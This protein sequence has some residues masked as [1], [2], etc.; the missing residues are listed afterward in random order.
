[1]DEALALRHRIP[2]RK[3]EWGWVPRA[4]RVALPEVARRNGYEIPKSIPTVDATVEMCAAAIRDL[5]SLA[6][7]IVPTHDQSLAFYGWFETLTELE[8]RGRLVRAALADDI[9]KT[10]RLIPWSLHLLQNEFQKQK[11][12]YA[13]RYGDDGGWSQ[14]QMIIE[15]TFFLHMW[16]LLGE[17]AAEPVEVVRALT[18]LA[19]THPLLTLADIQALAAAT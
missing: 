12:P 6:R 14:L 13:N 7:E 10:L 17:S 11:K 3:S 1:M 16:Q 4:A 19:P 8:T 15:W 5:T 9:R 18:A 2:L